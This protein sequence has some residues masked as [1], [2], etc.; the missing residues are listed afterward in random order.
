VGGIA[1]VFGASSIAEDAANTQISKTL[2]EA[3]ARKIFFPNPSANKTTY[4]ESFGLTEREYELIK[5]L[6][7]NERYFL[8]NFGRGKESVVV[9]VNLQGLED[10]I[11]VISGRE[12]TVKL[13]DQ[14]RSEVGNDPKVWLPIFH[15]RIRQ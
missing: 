12:N 11:A 2:N 4:M 8:L 3:A 10:E 9:R 15:E 1:I 13:L 6:D 7:N 14:I 5:K